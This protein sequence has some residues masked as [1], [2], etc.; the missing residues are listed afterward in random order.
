VKYYQPNVEYQ[1]RPHDLVYS[2][3]Q[4]QN[5]RWY[6]W[7]KSLNSELMNS[8]KREHINSRPKPRDEHHE[9]QSHLSPLSTDLKQKFH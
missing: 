6:A 8:N 1:V 9:K 3:I 2:T 7:I 4:N 5:L